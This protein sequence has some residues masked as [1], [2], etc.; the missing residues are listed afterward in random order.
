ML[1]FKSSLTVVRAN[2]GLSVAVFGFVIDIIVFEI[3]LIILGKITHFGENES[4]FFHKIDN[5]S[6][7]IA[8]RANPKTTTKSP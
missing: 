8:A 3:L 1:Y 5:I 4:F 7:T 6:K 2:Y